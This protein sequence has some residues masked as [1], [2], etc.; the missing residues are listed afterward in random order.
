MARAALEG[1]WGLWGLE[2]GGPRI[3]FGLLARSEHQALKFVFQKSGQRGVKDV[4]LRGELVCA[5]GQ[6]LEA[7]KD[8]LAT[9]AGAWRPLLSSMIV[10]LPLHL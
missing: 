4:G 2:C 3:P 9:P 8:A 7:G 6:G 1:W 5:V 10:C